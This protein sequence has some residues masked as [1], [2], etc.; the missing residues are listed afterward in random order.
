[1]RAAREHIVTDKDNPAMVAYQLT[2]PSFKFFWH[3]H[4]EYEL[5]QILSG[6]GKRIVGD[7]HESFQTGDLVLLGPDLPHT[8]IDEKS[9]SR[10]ESGAIVIQFSESMFAGISNLGVFD[11]IQRMLAESRTGL[12]FKS[13]ELLKA[14]IQQ[15]PKLKGVGRISALL[16]LLE[17]LSHQKARRLSSP[18]FIFPKGKETERRINKVCNFVQDNFSSGITVQQAADTIHLSPSAFCKFFKRI[19]GKTFSDYVNEI[20]I[21]NACVQ[22]VES[23]KPISVIASDCGFENLSYFNRVFLKKKKLRPGNYRN[24]K[25]Q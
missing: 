23:D 1:M 20:R 5:T 2:I 4:P 14:Q 24:L 10:K 25:S 8:W 6:S 7:S 15:L 22:L 9:K 13:N 19:T 18:R 11:N 12:S 3:Y 16:S 21:S 17:E